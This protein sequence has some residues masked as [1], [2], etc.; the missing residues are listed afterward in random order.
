[1]KKLGIMKVVLGVVLIMSMMLGGTVK[2][3]AAS[4]NTHVHDFGSYEYVERVISIQNVQPL[5][6]FSQG[7]D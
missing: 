4:A 1:M 6:T 2:T 5:Y 3:S 7:K